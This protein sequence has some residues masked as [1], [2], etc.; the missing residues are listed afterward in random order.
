M[1]RVVSC[2]LLLLLALLAPISPALASATIQ[3]FEPESMALIRQ[4]HQGRPF[5]LALWSS[6]CVYCLQNLELL[7]QAQRARPALQVVIV[8]TDPLEIA[9]ELNRLLA[10]HRLRGERWAFGG[11]AP[12]RL[13]YTID[14]AWQGELPRSYLFAAS[15]AV[16]AISGPI[17]R[18]L[19]DAL[20]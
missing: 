11:A 2:L 18:E 12:E 1:K 16:S 8:A 10:R 9:D 17:R 14:P 19:L 6:D 4:A 3:S 15:G 5:V 7:A 13:R 20:R